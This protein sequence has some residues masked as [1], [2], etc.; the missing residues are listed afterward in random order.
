[1]QK[2]AQ[3]LAVGDCLALQFSTMTCQRHH[4]ACGETFRWAELLGFTFVQSNLLDHFI[5]SHLA[6]ES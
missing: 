4:L 2:V 1:M 6:E 5:E 3:E